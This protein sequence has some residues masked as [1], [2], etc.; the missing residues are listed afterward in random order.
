MFWLVHQIVKIMWIGTC[1]LSVNQFAQF[2]DLV[3][4]WVDHLL[5]SLINIKQIYLSVESQND[6]PCGET[7]INWIH[8]VNAD[9]HLTV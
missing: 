7:V 8:A 6:T 1:K 3:R 4:G 5:D 9:I 2:D